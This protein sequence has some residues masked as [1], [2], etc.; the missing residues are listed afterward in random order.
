MRRLI[1]NEFLS[2][3]GV[4]QGPGSPDE[5]R[6]GG[7]QHGGWQADYDRGMARM[8]RLVLEYYNG[9]SFGRFVKRFP[10]LKGLL[11]DLLIGDL[12]KNDLDEVFQRIDEVK[13]EEALAAAKD[14]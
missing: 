3:D 4:M 12:F 9:F 8:R 1:V 7:F 5:D 6:D 11:T 2:V 13:A 14:A 10:H